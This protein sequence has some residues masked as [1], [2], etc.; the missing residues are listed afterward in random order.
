[1]SQ[2]RSGFFYFFLGE[3]LLALPFH[4]YLAAESSV[5]ALLTVPAFK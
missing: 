5:H 3:L 4:N 2:D 1:M